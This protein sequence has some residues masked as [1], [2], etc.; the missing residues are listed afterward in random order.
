MK[1]RIYIDTSMVAGY[2]DKEFSDATYWI[3]Y[4]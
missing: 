3:M 2:F 4:Y 1:Q